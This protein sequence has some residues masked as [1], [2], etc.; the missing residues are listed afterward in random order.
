MTGSLN[1]IDIDAVITWVD[2]ADPQHAAKLNAYLASLGGHRPNTASKARFHHSG[3]L[4]YC[5]ASILKFA[6]WIR[7]IFIVTDDQIPSLM[8]D[9]KGTEYQ[10]RI[11]II[12][13]KTIFSGYENSLP[14]FNSM[15]ITSLL[16]KI[17]TIAEKFIYFNDDFFLLRPV[18]PS[19]FFT[20]QGVVLRGK[21]RLLPQASIFHRAVKAVKSWVRSSDK[22][23]RVSYWRL[24]EACAAFLGFKKHYF[25]LPH[26]PHAWRKSSWQALFEYSV[27]A[28]N[29][30][31]QARLRG[32]EQF[33]PESLSA[34]YELKSGTATINN[35]RSNLQLKPA[36]Q[37]Y[38]RIKYKLFSATNNKNIV[39][40]CIQSIEMASP[41]K[42]ALIFS[43]L[44]SRVGSIGGRVG[45]IGGSARNI[46]T[47][48]TIKN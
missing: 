22:K 29:A 37:S 21:W 10:D 8:A 35:S 36:E 24:Q 31:I 14:T 40:G 34:H 39:F 42:Q 30:N 25:R 11:K 45:N 23:N 6:P 43:W 15:A 1:N 9:I 5:V 19:D 26:N 28:V 44:D 18:D 48:L 7:T 47:A 33:V 4:D 20:E 32:S 17:P 27:E 41:K 16:W 12:D 13:H 38:W 3:E 46:V 2:G